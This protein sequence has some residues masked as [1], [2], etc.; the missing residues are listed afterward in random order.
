M[1]SFRAAV[2]SAALVAVSGG[3]MAQFGGGT[4]E[5]QRACRADVRR[6]CYRVKDPNDTNAFLECLQYNRARLSR[7]CREVLESHGV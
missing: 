6:F 4:P 1:F 5:E 2:L 7:A 3:A